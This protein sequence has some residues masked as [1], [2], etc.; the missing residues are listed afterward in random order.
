ME[1]RVEV[2]YQEEYGTVCRNGFDMSA[3]S[4][5]CRQLGYSAQLGNVGR[6]LIMSDQQSIPK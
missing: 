5:V 6:D 3:A 1:G 4:V 2:C